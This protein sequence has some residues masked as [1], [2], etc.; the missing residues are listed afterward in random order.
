[1]FQGMSDDDHLQSNDSLA[2]YFHKKTETLFEITEK[3]INT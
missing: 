1:M 3:L 2:F